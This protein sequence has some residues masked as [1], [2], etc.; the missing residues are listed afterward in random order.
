M[1]ILLIL[2]AMFL[3]CL[4]SGR[5]LLRCLLGKRELPLIS[6][7]IGYAYLLVFSY[8]FDMILR[9]AYLSAYV[10]M[11]L[12]VVIYGVLA[13]MRRPDA[14]PPTPI[15]VDL[16]GRTRGFGYP[17]A[18]IILVTA[19]A[20][21]PYI[22]CGWGHYWHSGNEDIEDGLH[23]R[24][25]YLDGKIFDKQNFI[26]KAFAFRG[27]MAYD[28]AKR[29][30]TLRR[31]P[32]SYR[33][34]FAGDEF[35]LQY[36]SLAFWSALFRARDG[37]DILLIQSILDI[38]LML[39]G[40]YYLCRR[41]FCM[42]APVATMA[43]VASVLGCFYFTTFL[44]GHVGSLIYGALAPVLLHLV[45]ADDNNE[46]LPKAKFPSLS[47]ILVAM[48]FS[49]PHPLAIIAP[50]LLYY[51]LWHTKSIRTHTLR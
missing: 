4:F 35:R 13:V 34:A 22:L 21:W 10:T 44:A 19:I 49:Y 47:V 32:N 7:H 33:E 26:G 9:A 27:Q 37:I 6:I 20:T 46:L 17:L 51:K 38:L 15:N 29:T 41:S 18:A 50:S 23:G 36:S 30:G 39:I 45:I 24:D 8:L 2:L 25:A 11:L 12:P 43:G 16:V 42:T 1:N 3:A 48:A 28:F 31:E 5:T 14:R 40:I